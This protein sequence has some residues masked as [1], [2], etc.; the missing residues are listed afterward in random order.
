MWEKQYEQGRWNGLALN[1]LS[2]SLDGGKRLQVSDIPY[3]DLPDIKVMGSK[4]NKIEV[5]VILIGG[6]SL[7]EA[8]AL[9]DNLNASPKGELEH[10][11]L[12]EL[13]LVFEAYSQKI[14]TK[15]GLVTLSLKFVR[16]AKK[17]TLSITESTSTNSLEQANVVE[18]VSS[19]EFVSDV[20]NMSIAETNTLQSDFT[21]LIG[22]LT[23][24]A[25][26]LSIPSQ[27]LT[28]VNQEI[29]R[30]LM[31]ISSIANAPSQFAEQLSITVDSVAQAVRSGSNSMNPAVDNSRAAQSSMLALI[32]INSPSN[33][34]NI[35]LIIAALKMN[36]DIEHLE[37][38]PSFNILTWPKPHSVTLCDLESIATQIEARIHEVTTVS[39]HKSLL[40][41][42]AL[43]ELKKS[44]MVQRNKVEQGA[45]PHRYITCPHFIPALTLAQQ[46]G[47]SAA[48]IEALNPLLHPLFLSGTIAMG[49]NV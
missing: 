4:A 3:A 27:T 12:G 11:W 25:S 30:A 43:I 16:D 15:R 38:A 34:Y 22:E 40:L 7:V 18:S 33:H 13:S 29:N 39:T 41:F 10:P 49:D 44:V 8:N 42:D 24:I 47:H 1:I 14:S 9:L 20:E 45:K 36:K 35:Q 5:E 21:H 6:S 19:V 2:T 46:E 23:G 28:A 17:T 32:N 48:L 37:Q 31:A 26:R